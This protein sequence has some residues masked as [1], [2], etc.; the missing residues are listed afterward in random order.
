MTKKKAPRK[1][2]K[3]AEN[4]DTTG[5]FVPGKSG[6]PNGRP[7]KEHSVTDAIRAVMDAQPDTKQKLADRVLTMA[8]AGDIKAI[9]LIWHYMDGMPTQRVESKDVTDEESPELRTLRA[10][11]SKHERTREPVPG[12]QQTN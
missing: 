7:K 11:L 1:P 3:Q 2:D 8:L 4:R 10:I 9:T 12:K 6:N 5:K